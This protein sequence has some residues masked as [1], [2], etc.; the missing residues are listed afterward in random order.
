MS[1]L[2]IAKK[3]ASKGLYCIPVAPKSKR[4]MLLDWVKNCS[5]NEKQ[6]TYW[7]D[8]NDN[9]IG[10]VT[11]KKSGV[12]VIDIDV[13]DNVDGHKSIAEIESKLNSYL[14]ETVTS[15]T[16]SGG[17]HLWFSYPRGVENITGKIGILPGVDIRADGNQVIVYPSKGEKGEYNW[18]KPPFEYDFQPLPQAW[19][20]FICGELDGADLSKITLK[21]RKFVLPEKINN[22]LRHGTLLSYATSLVGKKTSKE[23]VTAGVKEANR[24]LCETP[25]P[26]DELEKIIDWAIDKIGKEPV[27]HNPEM[28]NWVIETQKG[29]LIIDDG[30]FCAEYKA[31]YNLVCV[32]SQFYTIDGVIDSGRIKKEIQT[33]ISPF[34]TTGL[35]TKVNV[36]LDGL[37]NECYIPAPEPTKDVVHTKHKSIKVDSSGYYETNTG[38]TLNRLNVEYDPHAICPRWKNFLNSL[39]N[40]EDVLTLQE[41]VGYCLVPVTTAQ[42]A[43]FIIG[44]GGE[45][46]SVVGEVIH[47]LFGNNMVQ[48]ELHK[49]QE[50]RFMIASLENKLVFYDDDLQT[51]ALTDTGTFKKLVTATV[52]IMVEQ[53][54]VP[55]YQILPFARL[56]CCGNKTIEACY[57]HSEG[58][59]RRLIVLKCKEKDPNRKDDR[60]LARK[61]IDNELSGILNWALDGLYRL[62]VNNWNFTMSEDTIHNLEE[63]KEDSNNILSFAKDI[64]AVA[65][66]EDFTATSVELYD[67]Y[68]DWCE[69]NGVKPLAVRTFTSFWKTEQNNYDVKYINGIIRGEKRVRGYKGIKVLKPSKKLSVF[70]LRETNENTL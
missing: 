11:G 34:V 44:Q 13:K 42:K 9:N 52:P 37:K 66:G 62:N 38:F 56:L 29:A 54:G 4:P 17:L 27:K 33:M 8:G 50:N 12:I 59:Y 69:D 3:Y 18:I 20:Q 16:Q 5:I 61:I 63:A 48:G 2:E 51:S 60:L 70:K 49:I 65:Y 14:P 43:L 22:G 26:D 36:L 10:I 46:K 55:H 23:L 31:K 68:C 32:N 30:I 7:F 45:G 47:A 64:T 1:T 15:K 67:A 25:L 40:P 21:K 35:S 6:L 57:D 28:P 58:F 24:T 41:Y 53:K 19:K 39:L